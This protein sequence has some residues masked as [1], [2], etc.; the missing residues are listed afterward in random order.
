MNNALSGLQTKVLRL[1]GTFK[2]LTLT[3][4]LVLDVGTKH[5]KYLW[6]K[7]S[8]LYKRRRPLVDRISYNAIDRVG[9]VEDFYYLTKYGVEF[10]NNLDNSTSV[11][12]APKQKV[13]STT[14]YHHRKLTLDFQIMIYKW[15]QSRNFTL[16]YFYRYFDKKGDNRSGSNL[17]SL[18][19]LQIGQTSY[20]IPDAL[21]SISEN[22]FERLFLF[23]L[24]IGNDGKR[25][26]TQ[27][28]KHIS[29]LLSLKVHS[30][31]GYP[32]QRAYYILVLFENKRT[33]E[34]VISKYQV[35]S[36]K[37]KNIQQ[38]ILLADLAALNDEDSLFGFSS[39]L[40]K[41]LSIRVQSKYKEP[42]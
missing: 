16:N 36:K 24:H 11:I 35:K 12:L 27:I 4:L 14:T 31:L 20:I 10:L 18:T 28:D 22:G 2:Y 21:F 3:Q 19:K 34:L 15:M 39:L 13:Q 29:A 30:Q 33:K 17:H 40:G 9:R 26:V 25:I 37:Y 8:E 6:K 23:E 38:Y 1:L 41:Q 5:Y 32:V 42:N 7:V